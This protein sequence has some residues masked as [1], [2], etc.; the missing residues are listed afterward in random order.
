MS[1]IEEGSSSRKGPAG[2]TNEAGAGKDGDPRQALGRRGEDFCELQL[3]RRG[4]RILD[5]NWRVRMGE[6]DFVAMDGSTLVVLEVKSHSSSNR[7]GPPTP[8][9]AVGP[10]KQRRL[11]RLASAW[12]M[13]RRQGREFDELRFDVVAITFAPDG[14][15]VC[16]EHIEN[17]F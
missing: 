6:I 14:S 7:A 16:H 15:L 17:A 8:A 3:K 12:L 2:D 10:Q 11:R 1:I 13:T 4:W 9:L 5:R